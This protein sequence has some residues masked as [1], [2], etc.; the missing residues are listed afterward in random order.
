MENRRLIRVGFV[1]AGTV[2][3]VAL[4]LQACTSVLGID[5]RKL[6]PQL[7]ATASGSSSGGSGSTSGSSGSGSGS[8]SGSSS[9]GTSGSSGSSSGTSGSGSGSTSGSGSGSGGD[10]GPSSDGSCPDPCTLAT[11]LNHPFEMTSD[12]NNV[13]WTEFGDDVGTANGSV[14]SCPLAGCGSG[15]TVI[16]QGQLNP[17][18]IAVDAQNVYWST[19]SY[20]GINGGIMSCPIAGCSGG[21]KRLANASTPFGIALDANYV[22]WVDGDTYTVSRVAKAGGGAASLL[23]DAGSGAINAPR[24]CAVDSS[25]VYLTDTQGG[26]YRV[27]LTGG[28]VIPVVFPTQSF[29]TYPLALDTSNVYLG[30]QGGILRASKTGMTDAGAPVAMNIQDPDG[31]VLDPASGNLYWSDWGSGFAYDGTVGKVLAA[32][33]NQSTLHAAL[34]SPEAVAVSGSDVFW[35]SNGAFDDAGGTIPSTGA[36]YRTAK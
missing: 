18:G 9:G 8:S 31:L 13:Y 25:F 32:G 26:A 35:I 29:G 2:A 22:Y 4:G 5:D 19:G 24:L 28:D 34:V 7:D 15:P 16:A 21:P 17:R 11:G 20:G 36:L 6:D 30:I 27:P 33:G 14:K 3:G 12:G 10:A 23:Y 1:S